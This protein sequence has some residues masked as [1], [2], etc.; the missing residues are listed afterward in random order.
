MSAIIDIQARQILDSRGNPTVEVDVVLEDG[1]F[2]RAAERE[3]W[4]A[5]LPQLHRQPE[6]EQA[7]HNAYHPPIF[8]ELVGE[9]ASDE[10]H[11]RRALHLPHTSAS[12]VFGQGSGAH[13]PA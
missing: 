5:L 6:D 12:W 13:P 10:G 8:D 7:D 2:G 3:E 4:L 9:K 1:S 11:F